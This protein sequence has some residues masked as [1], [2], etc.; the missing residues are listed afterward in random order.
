ME[1]IGTLAGGIAH[2]FNNIL[3]AI[4]GNIS[5]AKLNQNE[6]PGLE[7]LTEAEKACLRA[8]GLARQQLTFA[9]GGAPVKELIS[10][11]KL[12]T[13]S[14]SF[15]SRCSNVKCEFNFQDNLWAVK[16]DP[17]QINQVIQNLVINAMQAMPAGGTIEI[18]GENLMVDGDS[19]LPLEV[20]RY[21]K[22]SFRDQ[23]IGIPKEYLSKIFDPY[24]ST[25]Q[26]GSGLGLT[27]AY[28]IVKNHQGHLGI[29]SKLGE[30]TTFQIYLPATDSGIIEPQP[31]EKKILKGQGKILIMDDDVMIRS[32]LRDMLQKLGYEA[33]CTVNGEEAIE[34]YKEALESNQPFAA[35]IFDLTVPGAMGGK[36]AILKLLKIDPHIKVL[37]SS[38][39]SD[40]PIMANFEKYG[41]RGIISKPYRM[42]ELGKILFEVTNQH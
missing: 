15:A 27:T 1:A 2:D 37:V 5:L 41:F 14:T 26:T 36:D 20:G 10:I 32:M 25:K 33:Y 22:L 9:T 6:E 39:Y 38:G 35:A 3:T 31:D 42:A 11:E 21:V 8:Q 30:G 19:N 13:D 16:A 29:E 17:G 12:V 34:A 4:I 7:R 23:G 28:S 18:R 40:D 24:F